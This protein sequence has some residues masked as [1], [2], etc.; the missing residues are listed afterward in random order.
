M[1][2]GKKVFVDLEEIAI[3][4]F[5]KIQKHNLTPTIKVETIEEQIRKAEKAIEEKK[6]RE[7]ERKDKEDFKKNNKYIQDCPL[8]NR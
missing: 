7:R 2:K 4:K 6:E 3:N 8:F 1:G 5:E